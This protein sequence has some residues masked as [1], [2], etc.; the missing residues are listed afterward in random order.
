MYY[1][2]IRDTTDKYV[3]NILVYH[4]KDLG[5][6]KSFVI[7]D[8]TKH[9]K[10]RKPV[11][12][13]QNKTTGSLSFWHV[14]RNYFIDKLIFSDPTIKCQA[15]I[16]HG[17]GHQSMTKCGKTDPGHEIHCVEGFGWARQTAY[18]RGNETSTGFMDESPCSDEDEIDE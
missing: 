14:D 16:N 4:F 13:T 3:S 2:I 8:Y 11:Q 10:D 7:S 15:F 6:A 1:L 9:I 18:W 12:F 5:N 17:A